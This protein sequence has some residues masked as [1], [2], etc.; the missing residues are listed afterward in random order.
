V[1]ITTHTPNETHK[2]AADFARKIPSSSVVGLCGTL[3]AGKT[4]FVQ[5]MAEGLGIDPDAYVTSPTFALIHEYTGK[6]AVAYSAEADASAA[7]AEGSAPTLVHFD[8]YRLNS[9]EELMDIGLE[10]YTSQNGIV[11][12]EW[13]DRFE[14][15]ASFL[16]HRVEI[17]IVDE[18]TRRIGV[19]SRGTKNP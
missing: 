15:L 12:L 4:V 2:A 9:F 17:E 3:G 13:A 5:G 8:L 14:E 16:T 7:K 11:V 10:D 19:S 18:D 6:G 1:K